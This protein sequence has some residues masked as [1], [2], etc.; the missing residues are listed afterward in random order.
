MVVGKRRKPYWRR[1]K[2]QLLFGVGLPAGLI[3]AAPL[4]APTLNQWRFIGFPL[5]YFIA[6]HG[7]IFAAVFAVARFVAS[8]DRIDQTHGA[9]EDF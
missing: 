4:L 3:I 5:G 7:T 6:A 9:N 8:Q 1:T 2:W